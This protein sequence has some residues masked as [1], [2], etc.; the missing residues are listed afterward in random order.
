MLSTNVNQFIKKL[1]NPEL[2]AIQSIQNHVLREL[3][4]YAAEQGFS[5]LMPLLMSP[6]TDPLN[7]DVYPAEI[8]Y[9]GRPLKLTASMI[10]HKQLALI[11]KDMRKIL[12]MAP[13][14]RLEL[15]K[16]KSSDNH[17]LEFSQFDIEMRDATIEDVIQFSEGLFVHLF[18]HLKAHCADELKVLGREL[19]HLK[20]PFPK[21]STEGLAL[22][23]VDAFCNKLS[24]E[25][26]VPVFVTSFKRE[27]Y[28]RENPEKPGT[29]L[30]FDLVY[31]EGFGEAL[32]GAEREYQYDD[33]VRRMQELDMDLGPYEN[34]LELAKAG[35]IPQTAGC[36]IGIQRL[37]KFIC[38]KKKISD[39][40]LFDRSITTNFVF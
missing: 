16:K 27:F 12:I 28:D 20:A 18:D 34:Y 21:C 10:F 39:V 25:S 35:Q 7:H 32:S 15:A 14:I 31:P 13:N 11:P 9:E 36:G 6:I 22:D 24:E 33:I 37:M 4:H 40:C 1:N 3:Q 38:G 19:P 30:N 2:M 8:D 5:Q 17:L 23:E 29:Y 26:S